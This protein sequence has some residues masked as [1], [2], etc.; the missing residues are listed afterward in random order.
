MGSLS[1]EL[2]KAGLVTKKQADRQRVQDERREKRHIPQN[3]RNKFTSVKEFL[4]NVERK[5]KDS[6]DAMKEIFKAAHWLAD[7]LA[8]NKKKRGRLHAL[9][10]RIAENIGGMDYHE[11]T[12]FLKWEIRK[13]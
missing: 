12:E 11:R 9:L 2:L 6:P 5:L 3:P 1:D 4:E 13:Y 7:D 10:C 8:L